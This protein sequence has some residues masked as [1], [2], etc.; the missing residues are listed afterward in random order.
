MAFCRYAAVA[1]AAPEAGFRARTTS[2]KAVS[3]RPPCTLRRP[4]K[5]A[6]GGSGLSVLPGYGVATMCPPWPIVAFV[7]V[8]ATQPLHPSGRALAGVVVLA[9][10]GWDWECHAV[11]SGLLVTPLWQRGAGG[12]WAFGC[13]CAAGHKTNR[14]AICVRAPTGWRRPGKGRSRPALTNPGGPR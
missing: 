11:A 9:I 6:N 8:Q 12:I 7:A 10:K 1:P 3:A 5:I 2:R 13:R 14:A 4:P